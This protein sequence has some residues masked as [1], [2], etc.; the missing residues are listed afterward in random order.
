MKK[1]K[2][3]LAKLNNPKFISSI[4][5]ILILCGTFYW[6]EIRPSKIFSICHTKALKSAIKEYSSNEKNEYYYPDDYE[7]SYKQCLRK[8][9]I[10]K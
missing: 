3:I 4:A 1:I 7:F 6:Y 10:N 8:K 9:G 2:E 5:I